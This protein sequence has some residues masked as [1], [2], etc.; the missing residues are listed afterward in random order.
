MWEHSGDVPCRHPSCESVQRWDGR[1]GCRVT[2]ETRVRN[3]RDS[4]RRPSAAQRLRMVDE[5]RSKKCELN[6]DLG[7]ARVAQTA[8]SS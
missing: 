8:G 2:N 4:K 7:L 6:L 5:S 3:G 1:L